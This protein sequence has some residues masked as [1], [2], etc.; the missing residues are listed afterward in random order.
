MGLKFLRK[1]EHNEDPYLVFQL[2][3]LTMSAIIS[4]ASKVVDSFVG[5]VTQA[6][7]STVYWGKVGAELGKTIYKSEG[8]APPSAQQFQLVYEN[9]FKFIKSPQQQ[10]ELLQKAAKIRPT[11][12]SAAKAGVYGIQLLAFFSVG[13]IIG[14]RHIFGYPSLGHEH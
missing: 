1:V 2:N 4:K 6:T 5:K 13:E 11:K 14:R 7:N 8:L 12:E 3:N 9:A 10:R